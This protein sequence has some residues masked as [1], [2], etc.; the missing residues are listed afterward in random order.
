MSSPLQ[1]GIRLLRRLRPPVRT[2]AFSR[3][4]PVGYTALEFPSSAI[5]DV[6]ATRS[7]LLY[8]ERIRDS[9]GRRKDP[10]WPPPSHCGPGGSATCTCLLLRRFH[11]FLFVSMGHRG[12]PL[13]RFGSEIAVHYQWASHL[14]ACHASTHATSPSHR[15]PD[16]PFQA[17]RSSVKG[18]TT[19]KSEWHRAVC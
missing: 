1:R 19:Q 8:A 17:T 9:P 13:L 4:T 18:R 15:S 7:C 2:L 16:G 3:P 5:R 11:R 14:E 6:L 10:T 12:S